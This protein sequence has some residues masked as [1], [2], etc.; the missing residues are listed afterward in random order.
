MKH[1]WVGIDGCLGIPVGRG[2][3]ARASRCSVLWKDH[4][5]PRAVRL[6]RHRFHWPLLHEGQGRT[7]VATWVQGWSCG[8]QLAFRWCV[9]AWQALTVRINKDHPKGGWRI[10]V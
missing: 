6:P 9:N 10:L 3:A 8:W 5:S 4:I 2:M 1:S 7:L